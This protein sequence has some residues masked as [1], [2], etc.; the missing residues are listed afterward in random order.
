MFTRILI[1]IATALIALAAYLYAGFHGTLGALPIPGEIAT[2]SRPNDWDREN[3]EA[4]VRAVRAAGMGEERQI[5]FGDLH[6]HTTYSMD[7]FLT[8]LPIMQGEGAHPPA[9][10]CDF[11]RYCSALD[12]YSIND[13]AEGLT[14]DMWNEIKASV[15]Q[16]NEVAGNS[17]APD[18]V[19]FLGWEWTQMGQTPESHYGHKNV[20]L[21][22]TEE[23]RTPVRPIASLGNAFS[24]MRSNRANTPL[25]ALALREISKRQTYYDFLALRGAL[26]EVDLCEQDV[27]VRDLPSD[28]TEAVE[29]PHELFAK[30]DDWGFPSLVIPH[31]NA[32]GNTTPPMIDWEKQLANGD[33]DP[34]RQTL[35]EVYSG[36]GNSE[37]YRP[38]RHVSINM[39][40]TREC[41]AASEGFIPECQRAGQII[42]ARCLDAGMS[43]SEC[44]ERAANARQNFVDADPVGR[45]TVPGETAEDWLASGQCTDCF[46]PAFLYRP[47]GSAQNA[48]AVSGVGVPNAPQDPKQR[49][50]FGF[51]GSS[52]NHTARPASGYKEF[53]VIGMT[54]ALPA[55]A[56]A[57]LRGLIIDELPPRPES[58]SIDPTTV[59]LVPGGDDRLLSFFYTGGLVAV[60]SA[61]RNR[62]A[63]WSALEAKQVYGT[64]GP[65]M[66]LW[67]DLLNSP[68][69]QTRAM[70]SDVVM[71]E[72]P[73]FRVRAVG[74]REQLPGCPS[75]SEGSLGPER[76]AALCMGECYHPGDTRRAIARIE[77]VR[78]R[79]RLAPT[80]D[81]ANLID[82]PWLSFEC[83]PD[84]TG[85]TVDFEDADFA[86]RNRDTVYYVRAIE[87]ATPQ[88]NGNNLRCKID[89]AGSCVSTDPCMGGAG[90]DECI[91]P[92][93][94]QAWSSPIFVDRK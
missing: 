26:S 58:I 75:F 10:A 4:Q 51:I 32:W 91:A 79:P 84:E 46:E 28:C 36:H 15:R 29:T 67:F 9:D 2:Q 74:S 63:I 78:I 24:A 86:T 7:A 82:D 61:G 56:S 57:E 47:G 76:L 68:G 6:V 45:F 69:G 88:V 60:H 77:V 11:A 35:I 65:R 85:C 27:P 73:Q 49:F 31:G 5:L 40:G 25:M 37:Q 8:S 90:G 18:L 44:V 12:F 64:S 87:A 21:R 50:R 19:A 83:E 93:G 52:D 20:I 17:E 89:T 38:W 71:S 80:E 30:L 48:L 34:A 3:A 41:P 43:A 62:D 42:E 23:S 59:A 16:C 94:A 70:G 92:V 33:H 1:V 55:E 14:P 53:R 22:D 72:A 54:D 81:V 13:H 39:D 66:L